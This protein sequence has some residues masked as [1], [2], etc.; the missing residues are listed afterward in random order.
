MYLQGISSNF[1][2]WVSVT[3]IFGITN[4]FILIFKKLN[5]NLAHTDLQT[6]RV[7]GIDVVRKKLEILQFQFWKILREQVSH[8]RTRSY[9]SERPFHF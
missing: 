6:S 3:E 2:S 1:N 4:H 7:F 8:P 9:G 5:Y